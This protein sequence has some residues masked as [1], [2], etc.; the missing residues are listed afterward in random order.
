MAHW[1]AF[2][3]LAGFAGQLIMLVTPW[4]DKVV[5]QAVMHAQIQPKALAAGAVTRGVSHVCGVWQVH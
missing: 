2:V 3:S 1:S 4:R 5:E